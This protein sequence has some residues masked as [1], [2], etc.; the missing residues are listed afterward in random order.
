MLGGVEDGARHGVRERSAGIVGDEQGRRSPL[1]GWHR[2][3]EFVA[4]EPGR[5]I[6]DVAGVPRQVDRFVAE[7]YR[8][9]VGLG[10]AWPQDSGVAGC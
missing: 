9:R 1:L 7:L 10:A 3:R 5:G 2:A 8:E 4:S 6:G